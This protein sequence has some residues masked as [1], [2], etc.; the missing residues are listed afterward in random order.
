[1]TISFTAPVV[2]TRTAGPTRVLLSGQPEEI[3]MDL[4]HYQALGVRNFHIN[5][6]GGSIRQQQEVMEQFPREVVPLVP[7]EYPWGGRGGIKSLGPH[8]SRTPGMQAQRS[9]RCLKCLRARRKEDGEKG[10]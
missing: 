1:V 7:R 8:P 9:A 5:L 2:F 10:Q 4:R 3:A 6:Q